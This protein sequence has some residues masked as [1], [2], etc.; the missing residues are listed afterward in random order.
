MEQYKDLVDLEELQ[1]TLGNEFLAKGSD[2]KKALEMVALLEAQ[3]KE[4][5]QFNVIREN[6]DMVVYF[7]HWNNVGDDKNVN[8]KHADELDDAAWE[9]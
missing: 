9:H 8:G 1:A 2:L 4:M 5:M 7:D 3:M 6:T